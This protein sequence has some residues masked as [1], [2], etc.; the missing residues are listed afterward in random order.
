[1]AANQVSGPGPQSKRTD[2]GDVQKTRDLPNADYGEQQAY[3]AQQSG[4]PLAADQ[5]GQANL[6]ALMHQQN[7]Q[8]VV[9]LNAPTQRPGEPVTSGAATGPGPGMEALN[10][11]NQQ[12][13][14]VQGLQ[15]HLPV[16][17]FLANQPNASWAARNLVRTIKAAGSG[18]TSA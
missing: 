5:G 8:N 13:Q 1:V 7:V 12:Q 18:P 11:P 6:Q 2:I 3:Q 4:A 17:E 14:D 16:Y 10:L 15:A 9:P